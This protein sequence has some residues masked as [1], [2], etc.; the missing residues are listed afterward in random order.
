MRR[1]MAMAVALGL[2]SG[3]ATWARAQ[4]AEDQTLGEKFDRGVSRLSEEL[5]RGWQEVRAT[6]DRLGVQGRV[7]GRLHWDK[8]LAG[9]TIDIDVRDDHTVVLQGS[10]PSQRAKAKAAELAADTVGVQEVIDKLAVAPE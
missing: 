2:V 10:V 4:E 9:A 6:V 8:N 3:T 1:F 7:Y 5:R